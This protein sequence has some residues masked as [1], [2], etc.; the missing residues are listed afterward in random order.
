M[1]GLGFAGSHKTGLSHMLAELQHVS[2]WET[3]IGF[4]VLQDP[5]ED[6]LQLVPQPML[7][8]LS[9]QGGA[10]AIAI[11]PISVRSSLSLHCSLT[12]STAINFWELPPPGGVCEWREL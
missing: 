2:C 7:D 9:V 12:S 5:S 4:L 8:P 6:G 3:S 10:E 1:G 11:K